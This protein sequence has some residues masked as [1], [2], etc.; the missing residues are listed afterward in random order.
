MYLLPEK[1]NSNLLRKRWKIMDT[2]SFL[3]HFLAAAG[4]F[5][6]TFLFCLY[7]TH[8]R[9]FIALLPENWRSIASVNIGFIILE[10]YEAFSAWN[11]V[12]IEATFNLTYIVTA[13]ACLKLLQKYKINDIAL[14]ITAITN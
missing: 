1:D 4:A 6:H 8:K 13:S 11:A 7:P 5:M 14:S 9:Y 12:A 2:I 3:H 10:Y